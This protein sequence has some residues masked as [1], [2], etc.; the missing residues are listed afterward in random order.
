MRYAHV[1]ELGNPKP[2][3]DLYKAGEV[4]AGRKRYRSHL[5]NGSYH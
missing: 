3:R 5:H 4:E 2:Y 1:R